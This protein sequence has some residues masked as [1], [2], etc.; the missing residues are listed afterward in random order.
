MDPGPD[1]KVCP[2]K[3]ACTILHRLPPRG[4]PRAS[5]SLQAL[6][7]EIY[8][9][10]CWMDIR[11]DECRVVT[12]SSHYESPVHRWRAIIVTNS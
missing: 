7:V 8:M 4:D 9:L 1:E 5:E 11:E 2:T 6:V 3:F 10:W 12:D